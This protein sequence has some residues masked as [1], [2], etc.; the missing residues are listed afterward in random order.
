M[1]VPVSNSKSGVLLMRVPVSNSKPGVLLTRVSMLTDH[2]EKLWLEREHFL[3]SMF[4]VHP[5][6]CMCAYVCVCV[7]EAI[8]S[9]VVPSIDTPA[10][11]CCHA[12]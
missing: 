2:G 1:R 3:A 7:S 8:F 12:N 10:A 9:P 5:S 6:T 11:D 4:G